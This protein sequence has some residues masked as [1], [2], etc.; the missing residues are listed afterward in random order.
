LLTAWTFAKLAL[1]T[2]DPDGVK[3][4]AIAMLTQRVV[5]SSPLMRE[6]DVQWFSFILPPSFQRREKEIVKAL[7]CL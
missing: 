4:T 1:G 2:I 6:H 7:G 3:M 5:R